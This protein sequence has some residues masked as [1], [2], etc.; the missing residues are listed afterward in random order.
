M[1]PGAAG[2]VAVSGRRARPCQ[3]RSSMSGVRSAMMRAE[4]RGVGF[5]GS[6]AVL[7]AVLLAVDAV[8]AVDAVVAVVAV[9]AVVAVVAVVAVGG[10]ALSSAGGRGAV[11]VLLAAGGGKRMAG[12]VDWSG[13]AGS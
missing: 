9:D 7:L 10:V 11:W 13:L 5:A 6:L 12:V 2:S 8:D 4:G 1:S 3:F